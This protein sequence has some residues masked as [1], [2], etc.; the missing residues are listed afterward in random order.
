MINSCLA[1]KFRQKHLLNIYPSQKL[2]DIYGLV[3]D[4]LSGLF[5]ASKMLVNPKMEEEEDTKETQKLLPHEQQQLVEQLQLQ[6]QTVEEEEAQTTKKLWTLIQNLKVKLPKLLFVF[7]NIE[8][9]IPYLHNK[10]VNLQTYK[11]YKLLQKTIRINPIISHLIT[12]IT[13]LS[14]FI[15]LYKR[16]ALFLSHLIG[17]VYPIYY[18]L[19]AVERPRLNDDERWLTYCILI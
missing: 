2:H 7:K 19:Q 13:L 11:V 17:V 18:S 3:R 15:K 16:N 1:I 14:F 12:Q 6:Q 4:F 9:I 8:K 10:E 5:P